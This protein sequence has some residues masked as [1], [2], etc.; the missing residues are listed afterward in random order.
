MDQ[1]TVA[2]TT[3]QW[4]DMRYCALRASGQPAE[5]A[6]Y[7]A[8]SG[9]RTSCIFILKVWRQIRNPTSSVDGIS[10]RSDLKR[11]T[12]AE[13]RPIIGRV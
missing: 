13:H 10:S 2:H 1:G 7:A 12:P 3:T 6:A 4:R 8:M 9:G 5:A 11:R